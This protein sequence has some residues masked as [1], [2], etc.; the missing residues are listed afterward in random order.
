MG[1]KK[2]TLR[3]N[4][5]SVPSDKRE[6]VKE[7]DK[8][9]AC[10]KELCLSCKGACAPTPL[11]TAVL[12]EVKDETVEGEIQ[13]SEQKGLLELSGMDKEQRI[14]KLK[15]QEAFIERE[16]AKLKESLNSLITERGISVPEE[17]STP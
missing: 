10:L 5:R 6:E 16:L 7:N 3:S 1:S 11:F 17:V 2:R 14:E 13:K 4:R 8:S 15:Q 12:E 9:E